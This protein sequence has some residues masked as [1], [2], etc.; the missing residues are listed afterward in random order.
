MKLP[1]LSICIP[2]IPKH[3]IYLSDCLNS[4][5][6]Q[7]IRPEEVVIIL[8]SATDD[9]KNEF[10]NII[11]E[12]KKTLNII[13]AFVEDIQYA[14]TNRN[15]AVKLSTCEIIMFIDAD[16]MLYSHRVSVIKYLFHNYPDKIGILHYFTENKFPTQDRNNIVGYNINNI[17]NYYYHVDLHF[18][19]A[20]FRKSIFNE[21][22]YSN[23]P[24]GQDIEFVNNLLPKY[25]KNLMIY[26]EPLTYYISNRSSY[27]RDH[28]VY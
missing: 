26:K 1:T 16:D 28:P 14:G 10:L 27:W 4:I 9:I 6:N 19:H 20:C 18:G 7:T 8:S 21:F 12:Y 15:H 13:F 2:C 24:R 22:Q 17:S 5:I 25:I 11:L 23:K 3:I